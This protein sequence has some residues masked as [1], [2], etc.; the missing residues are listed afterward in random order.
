MNINICQNKHQ[1]QTRR[2][3]GLAGHSLHLTSRSS[4]FHSPKASKISL[5]P[6]ADVYLAACLFIS[7][8]LISHHLL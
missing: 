2:Q 6:W 4:I 5:K 1:Q 8:Q 3:Y 7:H